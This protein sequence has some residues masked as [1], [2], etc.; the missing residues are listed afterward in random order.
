MKAIE[1]NPDTDFPYNTIGSCYSSIGEFNVAIEFFQ[2]SIFHYQNVALSHVNWALALL[3]Q[4]REE[5]ALKI[6]E[7]VK[8]CYFDATDKKEVLD[9][10]K[11]E[12]KFANERLAKSTNQF[13]I[14]VATMRII[15]LQYMI[16]LINKTFP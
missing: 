1:L 7:K 15:G 13:D 5:D 2:K 6:F 3:L 11:D 9:V 10:Y 8:N 12:I 16:D 4:E 14:N